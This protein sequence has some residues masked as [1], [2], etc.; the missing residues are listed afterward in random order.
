MNYFM[1]RKGYEDFQF[2]GKEFYTN[3]YLMNKVLS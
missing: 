3:V 1:F 2:Y